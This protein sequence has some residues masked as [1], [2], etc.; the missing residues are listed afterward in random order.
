MGGEQVTQE[1]KNNLPLPAS[2]LSFLM[3]IK[4]FHRSWADTEFL[5]LLDVAAVLIRHT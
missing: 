4:F 1:G 2:P 5:L 3:E